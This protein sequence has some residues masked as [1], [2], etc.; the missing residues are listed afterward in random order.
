MREAAAFIVTWI[1]VAGIASMLGCPVF[2][3][4]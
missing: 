3:F 2:P 4:S 1:I